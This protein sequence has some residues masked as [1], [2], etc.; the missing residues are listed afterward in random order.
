LSV[1]T[2]YF[3]NSHHFFIAYSKPFL[4]EKLTPIHPVIFSRP[5]QAG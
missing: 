3:R 4:L 5:L 2:S 1:S